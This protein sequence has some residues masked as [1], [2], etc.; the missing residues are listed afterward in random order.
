MNTNLFSESASRRSPY[1][2]F[3]MVVMARGLFALAIV[4]LLRLCLS[5]G[6]GRVGERT[7][8]CIRALIFQVAGSER[9]EQKLKP[10]KLEASEVRPTREIL[11][12]DRANYW[13]IPS[14]VRCQNRT[15]FGL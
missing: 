2:Y 3:K 6:V 14:G 13:S 8:T 11:S 15:K 10:T 7:T 12:C 1:W 4:E 9:L 5:R